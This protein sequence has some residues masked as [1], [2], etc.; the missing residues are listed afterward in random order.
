M[1][2]HTTLANCQQTLLFLALVWVRKLL[3]PPSP[4]CV[5]AGICVCASLLPASA[6]ARLKSLTQLAAIRCFPFSSLSST[7][8]MPFQLISLMWQLT[9]ALS[10]P[11]SLLLS[12]IYVHARTVGALT[13]LAN[14]SLLTALP[15]PFLAAV[16][17]CCLCFSAHFT[18]ADASRKKKNKTVDWQC[19]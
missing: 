14:L 9:Q 4:M 11:L 15:P 1:C 6:S 5:C 12:Y 13:K 8:L 16:V 7:V 2:A 18:A 17:N 19:N 3:P 10:L